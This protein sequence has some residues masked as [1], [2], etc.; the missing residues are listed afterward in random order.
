LLFLSPQGEQD[1][2]EVSRR[3]L[4]LLIAEEDEAILLEERRQARLLRE[5]RA[6][7]ALEGQTPGMGGRGLSSAP[8]SSLLLSEF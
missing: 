8:V 1:L 2:P 4:D 7:L 5:R 3:D 6:Q